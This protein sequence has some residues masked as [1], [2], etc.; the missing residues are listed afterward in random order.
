MKNRKKTKLQFI[1]RENERLVNISQLQLLQHGRDIVFKLS[2]L[3]VGGVE[4]GKS[5][6]CK[7]TSVKY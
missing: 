6:W 2:G 3:E 7:T 5:E 1:E 4:G